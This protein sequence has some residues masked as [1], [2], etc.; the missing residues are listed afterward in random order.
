MTKLFN[1]SL[2][3][4]VCYLLAGVAYLLY[5]G[6]PHYKGHAH[7]PFSA[8]PEFLVWSPVAPYILFQELLEKPNNA[9]PGLFV[10]GVVF[11]GTLWFFFWK[12]SHA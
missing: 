9:L 1:A 10:F 12:K 4:A 7:V 5:F 11:A 8:F 6:W 2:K 3:I